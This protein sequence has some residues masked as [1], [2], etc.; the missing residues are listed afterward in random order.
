MNDGWNEK[1]WIE[2]GRPMKKGQEFACPMNELRPCVR[3]RCAW[4]S[5]GKCGVLTR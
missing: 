1:E 5:Y 4:W 3:E 2:A